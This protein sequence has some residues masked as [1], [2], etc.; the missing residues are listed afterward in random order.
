MSYYDSVMKL[1]QM[2]ISR[3][4]LSSGVNIPDTVTYCGFHIKKKKTGH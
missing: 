3:H 1:A 2:K 4:E